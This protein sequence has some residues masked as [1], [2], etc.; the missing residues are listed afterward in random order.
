MNGTKVEVGLASIFLTL[1]MLAL[2]V[3]LIALVFGHQMVDNDASYSHDN[4]T[5]LPLDS[6]FYVDYSSTTIVYIASLSSTLS[7]VLISA[8][9]LLFS[10]SL[11]NDIAK[12]S[13]SLMASH[14]PTPYQ[15]EMLIQMIDGR[16][17]ALWSYMLYLSGLRNQRARSVPILWHTFS[18][19][20]A[21]VL[22]A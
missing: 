4:S 8:A 21:F 16:L 19:L 7:T 10:F 1:P 12:K 17:M 22:L 5:V 2:T 20:T 14:L 9:M 11:A 18:I 6:A 3:V 13:D 15:L